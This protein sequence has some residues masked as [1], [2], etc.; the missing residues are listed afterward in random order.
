MVWKNMRGPSFRLFHTSSSNTCLER[1]GR[2]VGYSYTFMDSILGKC[3]RGTWED[4]RST[5]VIAY[6]PLKT[7]H[8]VFHGKLHEACAE[9]GNAFQNNGLSFPAA[10][11]LRLCPHIVSKAMWASQN[12]GPSGTLRPLGRCWRL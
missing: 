1:G 4:G 2:P 12:H 3:G 6:S 7:L 9:S 10:T 5:D 8:A 11:R